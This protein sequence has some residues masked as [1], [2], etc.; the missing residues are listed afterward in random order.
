MNDF[1][2]QL[3]ILFYALAAGQLLFC[4]VA[5]FLRFEGVAG[6]DETSAQNTTLT[7]IAPFLTLAA[8]AG[9]WFINQTRVAQGVELKGLNE[10]TGHYRTTIVIRSAIIEGG[11]IIML[12][13]YLLSGRPIH[14]IWFAV[15]MLL[16]LY[17]RPSHSNLVRNYQL[18]FEEESQLKKN[19]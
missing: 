17:F 9:A 18:S 10:K 11:N 15:G 16:F 14:L 3:N 6:F 2:K 1:F 8:F 7:M 5:I 12:I 13:V 19:H 4:A